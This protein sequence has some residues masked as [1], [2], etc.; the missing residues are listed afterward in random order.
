MSQREKF[1]EAEI[2]V[3][4]LA[5][6]F[7]DVMCGIIDFFSVGIA[8]IAVTPVVQTAATGAIE[9][10]VEQKGGD[11]GIFDLKRFAKYAINALPIIPTTLFI[12]SVTVFTHNNPAL[13]A[14]GKTV[15]KIKTSV[16]SVKEKL[17]KA[18]I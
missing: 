4:S 13:V 5:A 12:F 7:I 14:A 2:I 15:G 1:T 18:T 8:A 16:G 6:I 10:W 17:K 3:G 11:L 9:W